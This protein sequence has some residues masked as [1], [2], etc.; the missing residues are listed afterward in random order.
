MDPARAYA[1]VHTFHNRSPAI[2]GLDASQFKDWHPLH[3]LS[4]DQ[5][6]ARWLDH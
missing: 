4:L 6:V 1:E 2:S 3:I 5:K